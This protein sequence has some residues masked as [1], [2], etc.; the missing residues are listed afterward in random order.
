MWVTPFHACLKDYNALNILSPS[1]VMNNRVSPTLEADIC[2]KLI[3]H[4][5]LILV[6]LIVASTFCW[7]SGSGPQPYIFVLLGWMLL[8]ILFLI[9][10]SLSF[11]TW[12]PIKNTQPM[13]YLHMRPTLHCLHFFSVLWTILPKIIFPQRGEWCREVSQRKYLVSLWQKLA[14][15]W[16]PQTGCHRGNWPIK[17]IMF[18]ESRKQL[19]QK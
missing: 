14:S 11:G 19:S 5:A 16:H 15:R 9:Y 7:G 1:P 12:T 8:W 10:L 18:L 3:S 2:W 4:P 13:K 6:S 17:M